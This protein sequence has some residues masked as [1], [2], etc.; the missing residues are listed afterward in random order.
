MKQLFVAWTPFMRRPDSMQRHFGYELIFV[1]LSFNNRKFRPL[2]YLIKMWKTLGHYLSKKPDIIWIQLAPTFLLYITFLYKWLLRPKA[3]IIADCHNSMYRKPWISLP[4]SVS[5][6]NR[7]RMV[8]VHNESMMKVAEECGIAPSLLHVLEDH[9]ANIEKNALSKINYPRP[10][11]LFPCSFNSDEPIHEVFQAA[12]TAPEITFVLTGNP[13]RAKGLH[14]L[15]NIPEN[16]KIAGF[17]PK[18]EFDSMICSADLILALTLKEGIQ[19]SVASEAVGAGKPMVL[20]NTKTLKQL[21]HKGAVLVDPAD[22]FSIAEGCR[23][24]IAKK[25]NLAKEVSQ[26]REE[27][28]HKWINQAQKVEAVLCS[29]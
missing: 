29:V 24:A 18:D 17:V 10:W 14:D 28:N 19:L 7:C 20:A 9:P 4:F 11:V 25:D 21:F 22:G 3:I 15:D 26:L 5:L 16:V 6:L 2:E 13:A 8:I 23:Q 12:R 27:R 1:A